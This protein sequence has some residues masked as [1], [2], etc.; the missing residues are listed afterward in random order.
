[1]T[2]SYT[3]EQ[4]EIAKAKGLSLVT[5]AVPGVEYQGL[6]PKETAKAL[7]EW[8]TENVFKKQSKAKED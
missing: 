5:V 2:V 6:V 3:R 7:L 8:L 1:V 4:R